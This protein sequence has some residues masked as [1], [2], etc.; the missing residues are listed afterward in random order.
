MATISDYKTECVNCGGGT[1]QAKVCVCG[2]N[3][4]TLVTR[5]IVVQCDKHNWR[6]YAYE[7]CTGC[8]TEKDIEELRTA[9]TEFN[10]CRAHNWAGVSVCPKC[11]QSKDEAAVSDYNRQSRRNVEV[12]L[13]QAR[14]ALNED[15]P[16]TRLEFATQ[17]HDRYFASGNYPNTP[18]NLV[19]ALAEALHAWD[20]RNTN[21][22]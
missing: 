1:G 21:K 13:A 5:R 16:R 20:H 9:N 10:R 7:G 3:R 11:K 12:G 22:S 14:A 17:F 15:M 6:G 4:Q 19:A 18:V 2:I 8:K